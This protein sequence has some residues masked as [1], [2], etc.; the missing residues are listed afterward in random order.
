MPVNGKVKRF[1]KI[2]WHIFAGFWQLKQESGKPRQNIR[3][4]AV[5]QEPT[6][7]PALRFGFQ[8]HLWPIPDFGRDY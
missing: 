6:G 2:L 8:S 4:M 3:T 1:R 5:A 7:I